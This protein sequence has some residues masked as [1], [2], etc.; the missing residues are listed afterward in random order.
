MRTDG[1]AL[2][3]GAN[4]LLGRSVSERLRSLGHQ[5]VETSRR[6]TAGGLRLDMLAIAG[7]W[8]PPA[9]ITSAYF[10][11]AV[12]SQSECRKSF[13]RA[14][15]VN[16]TATVSLIRRLVDAGIFVVFPSTNLVFDGSQP[17]VLADAIPCPRTAYGRMK[18]EAETQLLGLGGVG[19][20]RL[21][22]VVHDRLPI[23]TEWRTALTQGIA[24]H[25]FHDM[26]FSPLPV[27][28]AVSV[29]VAVGRNRLQGVIQASA[30][31]DISYAK[32]CRLFV[33]GLHITESQ[34]KP[35]S[36]RGSDQSPE[37]VPEH[38]TL[39]TSRAR[40][41]CGFI[42]PS[43][44]AAVEDVIAAGTAIEHAT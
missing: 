11:A 2:V 44:Q 15:A 41:F 40:E 9:G 3:I 21:T 6:P 35:A 27:R 25:P 24:V 32:A 14:Y 39:D 28:D 23:F 29:L 43:A 34:V 8:D 4:G 26:V 7:S 42:P 10:C 1:A 12:T 16:V 20:V 18:A 31:D 38:T 37:H 5:V 22:K 36:W 33:H 30:Q 19:V 13:D 17:H